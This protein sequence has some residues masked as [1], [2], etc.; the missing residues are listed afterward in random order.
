MIFG[1]KAGLSIGGALVAALLSVVGYDATQAAQAPAVADGIR[2][3]I[4]LYAAIPFL[5]AVGSLMFYEIRKSTERTIERE[6]GLRRAAAQ[7]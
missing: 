4:S 3:S 5:L 1:L 6:L 2:L 7:Q